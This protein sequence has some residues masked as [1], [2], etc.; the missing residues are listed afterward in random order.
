MIDTPGVW[1]NV[2]YVDELM[3]VADNDQNGGNVVDNQNE[4]NFCVSQKRQQQQRNHY[5]QKNQTDDSMSVAEQ[6]DLDWVRG[7]WLGRMY[8]GKL[9]EMIVDALDHYNY[10]YVL[11]RYAGKDVDDWNHE[12]Y[13]FE[14]LVSPR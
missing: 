12:R 11:P 14:G 9:I 13:I 3:N 4:M 1:E 6:N 7:H 2:P 10:K 8:F 5:P